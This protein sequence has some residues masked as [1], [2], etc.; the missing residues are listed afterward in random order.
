MYTH[1]IMKKH[2]KPYENNI[3]IYRKLYENVVT[4][5]IRKRTVPVSN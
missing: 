1:I 5:T 4:P 2:M 3:K